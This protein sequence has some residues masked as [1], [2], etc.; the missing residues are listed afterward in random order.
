[1]R[2]SLHRVLAPIVVAVLASVSMVLGTATPAAACSCIGFEESIRNLDEFSAVFI[3][4]VIEE[5]DGGATPWGDRE[6]ELVF[7]VDTLFAGD[8]TD[9][10]LLFSTAPNGSNCG[11]AGTA[12]VAVIG[13]IDQEQRL[14]TNGCSVATPDAA[15]TDLLVERFGQGTD[16]RPAQ[17]SPSPGPSQRDGLPWTAIALGGAFAAV[18]ATTFTLILRGGKA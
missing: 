18:L 7:D 3:G 17:A 1:M 10:A 4:T 9:R 13:Y 8:L 15:V 5:R 11:F 2:R 12:R 6:V 14:A 16:P